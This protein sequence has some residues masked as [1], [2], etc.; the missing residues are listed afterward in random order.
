MARVLSEPAAID[1]FGSEQPLLAPPNFAADGP[2]ASLGRERDE[3]AFRI[4]TAIAIAEAVVLI[5]AGIS[6]SGVFGTSTGRILVESVPAAAEVR[7]DGTLE[8]VTPLSIAVEEG[9]H[10]IEVRH[11]GN[12]QSLIVTVARGETTHSRVEFAAPAQSSADVSALV[13]VD[14]TERPEAP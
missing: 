14:A 13:N 11:R 5:V 4:V 8:G 9:R 10:A 2:L 7:L 3:S 12:V 1:E 6:L